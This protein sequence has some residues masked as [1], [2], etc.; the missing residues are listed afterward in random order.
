[1]KSV[2]RHLIAGF[3]TIGLSAGAYAQASSPATEDYPSRP[4]RIVVAFSPGTGSDGLARSLADELTK[5]LN[6][7]IIVE[8]RVGAGGNIGHG[9]VAKAAPDGYTL[10]MGTSVMAMGVHTVSPKPYNNARDFAPVT[11]IMESPVAALVSK[12]A[13][14]Q[15]WQ[16]FVE[17]AKAVPGR[18]N[19]ITSG[20]GGSSHVL[21]LQLMD[22]FGFDGVDMPYT[23]IGQAIVD[24][25]SQQGDIF[26][27]NIPPAR[28]LLEKGDLKIIAIG[29]RERLPEFPDVPTFAELIGK[30]DYQL[31]LWYGIL[32]PA[33]TPQFIIDKLNQAINVAADTPRVRERV[34]ASGG[35]L[36]I[37]GPDV[38]GKQLRDD[39]ARFGQMIDAMKI[40]DKN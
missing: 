35:I 11:R 14:H 27:A 20:K 31:V 21:M 8:N 39:D 32:A 37:A 2:Y 26:L 6:V 15:T 40:A 5:Q 18:M 10:L 13:K 19:Y 29:S 23:N 12:D 17:Y 25:A 16:E 30:K 33:G 9:S 7:P 3:F 34:E 24:T 4:I 1:M 38:L 36:S 28:G 22:E